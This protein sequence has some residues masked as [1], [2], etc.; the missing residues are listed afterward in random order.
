MFE[1]FKAKNLNSQVKSLVKAHKGLSE[2]TQAVLMAIAAQLEEHKDISQL[3]HLIRG[4]CGTKE[5]ESVT[6]N[7]TAKQIG[8]YMV[9]NL[10]VVWN[11]ETQTFK[12]KEA[13]E[14]W[15]W[16]ASYVA[17]EQTRWDM[18]GKQ[19]ADDA[20]DPQKEWGKVISL[21]KKI[22]ANAEE[23]NEFRTKADTVIRQF[24]IAVDA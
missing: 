17:M 24:G 7:S 15:D 18:Y 13:F 22:H 8:R 5:G 20:F 16:T 23:G 12:V 19:K 21:V 4:L 2:K 6:L 9:D 3:T 1:Q 14:G 10:P 11:K